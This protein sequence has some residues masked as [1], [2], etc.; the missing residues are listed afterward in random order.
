MDVWFI[1]KRVW[2]TTR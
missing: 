1:S 2:E